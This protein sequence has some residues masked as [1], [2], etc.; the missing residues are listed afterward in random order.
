MNEWRFFIVSRLYTPLEKCNND[1]KE[2]GN[3]SDN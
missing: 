2:K 3:R 1:K